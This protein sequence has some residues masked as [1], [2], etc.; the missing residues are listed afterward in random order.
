VRGVTNPGTFDED[1][2]NKIAAMVRLLLS[3][4]TGEADAAARML[5]RTLR[6][7]GTDV[8]NK[9]AELVTS[10]F[11]DGAP[12]GSGQLSEADMREIFDAGIK[13]GLKRATQSNINGT[14]TVTMPSARDMAIFCYQRFNNL[15]EWE[16]G[17]IT[18]MMIWTRRRSLFP[19]QQ[20]KLEQIYINLGG[21]I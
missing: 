4:K 13:E 18:N 12:D 17:F 15:N 20:D 19:K 9:V 11:N 3:D 7:A 1:M 10:P 2:A 16:R 5:P 8:V 21:R 6:N 14:N